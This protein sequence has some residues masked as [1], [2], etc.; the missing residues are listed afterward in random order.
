[1][2]YQVECLKVFAHAR[3]GLSYRLLGASLC[4]QTMIKEV[5]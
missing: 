3:E 4:L 1:M 2:H 5:F